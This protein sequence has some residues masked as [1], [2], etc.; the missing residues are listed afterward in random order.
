LTFGA[1]T[2]G[3]TLYF[4]LKITA[5]GAGAP[6]TTPRVAY[7]SIEVGGTW[8]ADIN[9]AC[10]SRRQNLGQE[11]DTQGATAADLAYLLYLAQ[12]NGNLLTFY[13]PNGQTYTMAIESLDG[14]NPS[15]LLSQE[16]RPQDEEYVVHAILRQLA[17]P[18]VG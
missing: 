3:K 17:T 16:N 4:A 9:L 6:T 15:P 13:H 10:T 12:E 18:A 2:V 8:V 5:G 1:D 7:V 11:F 14:W